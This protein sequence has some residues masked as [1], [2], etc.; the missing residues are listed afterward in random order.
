MHV[1]ELDGKGS[2]RMSKFN[3]LL[4]RLRQAVPEMILQVGGSISFAPEGEGADAKW[5]GDDTR[6]MLAE[7]DPRA[8]PGDHRHQHRQMNIVELM[9]DEDIAGTSFERP[10]LC[11]GLPRTW[12]CP[13]SPAWVEEHLRRLRP[14]RHPAALPA[15]PLRPAR[16]RGAARSAAASTPDRSTSP[17]WPSAAAS[18]GPTPTRMMDFIRRVPDGAIADARKHHAQRPADQH[19]G[20]RHGSARPLRQRGQP[21][22]QARRE[23]HL[24]GRRSSSWSASPTSSAA[25]VATGKEAREIY[26]LGEHSGS[27]DETLAKLGYPPNRRPGQVGFL[28]HA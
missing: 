13:P 16:D 12:T 9:T 26:K 19:D 21:L 28:H 5:L 18:T 8:R 22:A 3:E 17:G 25:T 14:K 2:K 20:D 10:E 4:A 27:T 24:G 11:G 1:R 15:G 6:H 23:D 7:L